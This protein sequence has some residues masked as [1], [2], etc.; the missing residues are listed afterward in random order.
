MPSH[1]R[2]DFSDEEDAPSTLY[3]PPR[4]LSPARSPKR[5]RCDVLETGMS[6][7]TLDGRPITPSATF[8][9]P[10]ILFPDSPAVASHPPPLWDAPGP[11]VTHI[12]ASA[13]TAVVLPGSV[14]EPTSPETVEEDAEV[15]DV[16]MK[17]P[18]WYEIEKDRIVI[19]DLEDYDAEDEPD[20]TPTN[21]PHG[22]EDLP[23]F[24]ISSAVLDRLLK[25]N[26]LGPL[27]PE[28]SP[29]TALVLYRPLVVPDESQD[30]R[31][32]PQERRLESGEKEG[33]S[34]VPGALED[35]LQPMGEEVPMEDT[36]PCTPMV[37]EPVD[38]PVDE[39][40]D[41]EML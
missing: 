14:E 24:S 23:A 3:E 26:A 9:S 36:R 25:P 30:G 7:L 5:R 20:N 10:T 4:S 38:E 1:K 34:A 8:A 41:I 40:M 6:Q 37:L 16:P 33:L 18:S 32:S 22:A 15:Q 13:A 31:A 28:P 21:P 19:T 29:S 12:P 17:V 27:S 35:A 11:N 39:P 2:K